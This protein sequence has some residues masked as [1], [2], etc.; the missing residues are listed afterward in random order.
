MWD[1]MKHS[2]RV[3]NEWSKDKQILKTSREIRREEG[4][5]EGIQR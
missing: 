1:V 5:K 3:I 2:E 4:F